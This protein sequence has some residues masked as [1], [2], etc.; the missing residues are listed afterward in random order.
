MTEQN[1]QVSD[2]CTEVMYTKYIS[3]FKG[4]AKVASKGLLFLFENFVALPM[5][6]LF[7]KESYTTQKIL[8]WRAS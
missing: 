8:Y 1:L 4:T 6:L 2:A 5:L 7:F 3:N